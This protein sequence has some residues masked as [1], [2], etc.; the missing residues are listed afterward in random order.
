MRFK[1]APF[2]CVH[3]GRVLLLDS[4]Q[5]EEMP[6]D[7]YDIKQ[8]NVTSVIDY[9]STV[10]NELLKDEWRGIGRRDLVS[11][12]YALR[13]EIRILERKTCPWWKKP[14]HRDRRFI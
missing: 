14:W 3:C 12:I 7:T 9:T 5:V 8:F 4:M 6:P 1:I 2:P 13:N 10:T 11:K